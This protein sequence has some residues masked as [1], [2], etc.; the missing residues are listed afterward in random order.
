MYSPENWM[1]ILLGKLKHE[2]H[3]LGF[4]EFEYYITLELG[5]NNDYVCYMLPSATVS[6]WTNVYLLFHH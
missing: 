3:K 1:Q 2:R 5:G 4:S 6:Y